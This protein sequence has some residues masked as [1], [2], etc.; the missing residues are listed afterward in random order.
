MNEYSAIYPAELCIHEQIAQGGSASLWRVSHPAIDDEFVLKYARYNRDV[1]NYIDAQFEREWEVSRLLCGTSALQIHH[2]SHDVRRHAYLYMPLLKAKSL[3]VLRAEWQHWPQ[4]QSVFTK[5]AL[6][7]MQIHERGV[8]HRDLKP[9]NVMLQECG[10]LSI[11]DFGLALIK[12]RA[13]RGENTKHAIGTPLFI[14]PEQAFGEENMQGPASDAYAFG[15]MLFECLYD[16]LP[17]RGSCPEQSMHMHCYE[18]PP[19][20]LELCVS[21]VPQSA[22]AALFRLLEKDPQRRLT[23]SQWLD[24]SAISCE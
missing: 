23:L 11:I 9:S 19:H 21:G 20:H 16:I 10:D 24:C 22:I 2:Y 3:R 18:E 14:S 12:E 4:V 13:A 15:V 7:L 6:A 1:N 5:L 8:V 17:F